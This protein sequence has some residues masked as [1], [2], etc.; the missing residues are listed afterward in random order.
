MV[1]KRLALAAKGIRST[2]NALIILDVWCVSGSRWRRS[3]GGVAGPPCV[4]SID[5]GCA[6]VTDADGRRDHAPAAARWQVCA[7]ESERVLTA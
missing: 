2:D 5:A 7:T 6:P 4:P 1:C 3:P